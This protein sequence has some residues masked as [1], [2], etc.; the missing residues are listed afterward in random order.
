MGANSTGR[1]RLKVYAHNVLA[2]QGDMEMYL[3]EGPRLWWWCLRRRH[4]GRAYFPFD[5]NTPVAEIADV[6]DTSSGKQ[7]DIHKQTKSKRR[8][9]STDSSL[10]EFLPTFHAE[11]N[12]RL[13]LISARI[14]YEFDMGKARQEVFDKLGTVDGLTLDQRYEL[15]DILGDKSQSLESSGYVL[16]LIEHN[17][18]DS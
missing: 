17:W 13:E 11:T 3:R 9:E 4:S 6:N 16:C 12:S 10:I 14:C 2:F 18:K 5:V 15:C 1:Q 8:K 7:R